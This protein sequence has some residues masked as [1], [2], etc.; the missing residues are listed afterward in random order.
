MKLE[1]LWCI[2]SWN[3]MNRWTFPK[4]LGLWGWRA[5][6]LSSGCAEQKFLTENKKIRKMKNQSVMC[7]WRWDYQGK[8]HMVSGTTEGPRSINTWPLAVV[9]HTHCSQ[10]HL[11]HRSHPRALSTQRPLLTP[12]SHRSRAWAALRHL[13]P[14]A[15]LFWLPQLPSVRP[16]LSI[17]FLDC[18]F[19]FS[20]S[21]FQPHKIPI[22]QCSGQAC[23]LTVLNTWIILIK[24]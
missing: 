20:F 3:L 11:K 17:C 14:P 22:L 21:S 16:T 15:N 9:H 13:A 7:P 6:T 10:A 2:F 23:T 19:S 18:L 1:L 8:E 4:E 12:S 5:L 24:T